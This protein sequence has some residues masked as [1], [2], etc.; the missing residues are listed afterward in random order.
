MGRFTIGCF[1]LALL[2][3]AA[4]ACG[5]QATNTPAHG[6]PESVWDTHTI[7]DP[8]TLCGEDEPA[9]TRERLGEMVLEY[10]STFRRYPHFESF[11]AGAPL[12]N[13]DGEWTD[14]I[15]IRILV[16]VMVDPSTIPPKYRLPECLEGVPVQILEGKSGW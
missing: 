15:G 4:M 8:A 13:D 12:M 16:E 11:S 5:Q 3:A 2:L 6:T 9:P 14:V 10:Q 7:K 1:V